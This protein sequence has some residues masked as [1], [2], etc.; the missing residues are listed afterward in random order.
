MA[1]AAYRELLTAYRVPRKAG[2]TTALLHAVPIQAATKNSPAF[3]VMTVTVAFADASAVRH[4][5]AQCENCG[6][7]RC[8]PTLHGGRVKLE[9]RLPQ[10]MQHQLIHHVIRCVSAGEF[11]GLTSWQRQLALHRNDHCL[12]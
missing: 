5:A 4:A 6:V 11:S 12:A 1:Y 8:I 9:L 3:V 10:P 7:L 2:C